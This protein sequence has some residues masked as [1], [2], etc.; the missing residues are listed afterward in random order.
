VSAER[1]DAALRFA[2]LGCRIVPATGKNP[3]GYLGTGWQRKASSDPELISAWWRAWPQANV[4]VLG[5]RAMLPA[6]VDDPASFERFQAEHGE[7]P[8]TPRYLSGGDGGRERLLFAFP[9]ERALAR[10]DRRLCDGVQLRW[11]H[12]SALVCIVP[13]GRNPDTGRELRWTVGL[14]EAPLAPIPPAWLDRTRERKPGRGTSSWAQLIL[15][16]YQTG[17]GDTHPDVVSLA[18]WLMRRLRCGEVV[19]ELLLCWNERHC[20]PPK[21]AGEIESIVAWVATREA[22]R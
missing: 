11:S 4:A 9:G 17:C 20:K 2:A 10:A 13:P 6:D 3:G 15:R 19:L 14:E 22:G 21:P 16:D 12:N 7:A 8:R 5:D 1:V 18:A